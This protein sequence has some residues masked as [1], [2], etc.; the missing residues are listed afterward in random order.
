MAN[1]ELSWETMCEGEKGLE[2]PSRL[3]CRV[4]GFDQAFL[5]SFWGSLDIVGFASELMFLIGNASVCKYFEV[6]C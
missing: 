5:F 2:P 4:N 1:E 6:L 3:L